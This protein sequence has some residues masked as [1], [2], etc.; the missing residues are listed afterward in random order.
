M[1]NENSIVE[2]IQSCENEFLEK[3]FILTGSARK[4][5]RIARKKHLRLFESTKKLQ[6]LFEKTLSATFVAKD[7]QFV[8]SLSKNE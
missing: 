5:P 2:R 3:C 4:L 7:L 1:D 8:V 6:R